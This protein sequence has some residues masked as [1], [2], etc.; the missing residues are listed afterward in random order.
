[1]VLEE[2]WMNRIDLF[3]LQKIASGENIVDKDISWAQIQNLIH[4]RYVEL[5]GRS[6]NR[7]VRISYQL[8]SDIKQ[9]EKYILSKWMGTKKKEKLTLE[10]IEKQ[11]SINM[12][13]VYTLFPEANKNSLRVMM[14]SM[15]DRWELISERKNLYT[16]S[17]KHRW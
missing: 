4:K 5:Y 9:T 7:K 15:K 6:P 12:Q 11:G 16:L 1:M 17:S 3:L 13:Q 14:K 2:K 8:L 10:Y